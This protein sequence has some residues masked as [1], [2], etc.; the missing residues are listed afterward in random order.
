MANFRVGQKVVCV[1]FD[2][3]G[4]YGDELN[5]QP[6]SIYTV[7]DVAASDEVYIRLQEIRNPLRYYRCIITGEHKD[8]EAWMRANRFRPVA[9]KPTAMEIIKAIVL[10]PSKPIPADPRE[11][12]LPAPVPEYVQG[13]RL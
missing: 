12:K 1:Y 2:G 9:E 13:D 11:P 4:G 7:R 8:T 10:D 3:I 6:G 5:P